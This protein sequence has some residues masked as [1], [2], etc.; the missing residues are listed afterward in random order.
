MKIIFATDL[1]GNASQYEKVFREA[2]SGEIGALVIGGDIAPPGGFNA[3][4]T[5]RDFIEDYLVPKIANFK[6][7]TGKDV[8]VMM[9]NDD[10]NIN[11]DIIE[12]ADAQG[13][14]KSVHNKS[15]GIGGFFIAGYSFISTTPFMV[16]DWE[17]DEDEIAADLNALSQKTDPAKTIFVFHSPPAETNLDMLYNGFHAGSSAVLGFIKK[18][19]PLATLHGHIHESPD[20]S[21]KWMQKI[22]STVSMNPGSRAYA[23]VDLENPGNS[24]M[25]KY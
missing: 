8:F 20:I 14:L 5:Q 24:V 10:F 4:A 21:G 25:K 18:K 3:M 12:K 7:K 6:G 1:H 16:K 17:K 19:Q 23:I 22:G 11:H 13:I 9:G 15:F 2:E